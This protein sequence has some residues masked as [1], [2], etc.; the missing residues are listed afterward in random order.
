VYIVLL[1]APGSGKG[2]QAKIVAAELNLLHLSTGDEFRAAIQESTPLGRQVKQYLD[3]GEL[4][5]DSLTVGLVREALERKGVGKRG[6]ILDGFPRTVE[7]AREL[8]KALAERA[9]R[10]DAVIY[11]QVP[12]VVLI[13]RLDLRWTCGNCGAVYGSGSNPP[14]RPGT[15][16]NCGGQLTRRSDDRPEVVRE[17][18]EEYFRKT[19]PVVDYYRDRDLLVEIDGDQPVPAVT[20]TLVDALGDRFRVSA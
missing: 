6:V 4:V 13:T 17:R 9:Q 18:L 20:R 3:R 19:L 7:Q 16:D 5:P 2:T 14:A 8:D 10:V 15:C 12:D 1:G 11:L